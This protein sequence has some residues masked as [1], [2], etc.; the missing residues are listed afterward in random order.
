MILFARA[1]NGYSK[2]IF[3]STLR[4][5]SLMAI[6]SSPLSLLLCK[7][8]KSLNPTL[9]F[10]NEE[11]G[12]YKKTRRERKQSTRGLWGWVLEV[13][14]LTQK[15]KERGVFNFERFETL[16][17]S[18]PSKMSIIPSK[19]QSDYVFSS[20]STNVGTMKK[21]SCSLSLLSFLLSLLPPLPP[22][23]NKHR[24]IH[25]ILKR[26]SLT[27]LERHWSGYLETF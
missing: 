15:A 5:Y 17:I 27:G 23:W 10:R 11:R 14:A 1:S 7:Q 19:S 8:P 25:L 6:S 9:S 18:Q 12:R 3:K 22:E 26:L 21:R 4:C 16:T 20:V 24:G 13:T 2:G